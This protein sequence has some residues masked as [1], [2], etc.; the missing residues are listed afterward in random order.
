MLSALSTL[1]VGAFSC[2]AALAQDLHRGAVDAPAPLF[3]LAA[4]VACGARLSVTRVVVKAPAIHALGL[5]LLVAMAVFVSAVPLSRA[6]PV[7]AAAFA[8]LPAFVAGAAYPFV[9]R[10]LGRSSLRARGS[11]RLFGALLAGGAVG[12][13]A[14]EW[15]LV[16][17]L[18]PMRTALAA[19]VLP[20]LVGVLA[21]ALGGRRETNAPLSTPRLRQGAP[22]WGVAL[23]Y[24]LAVGVAL[25]LVCRL[26]AGATASTFGV[27][28]AALLGGFAWG[29]ERG[30]HLHHQ[31]RDGALSR[32]LAATALTWAIGSPAAPRLGRFVST[33]DSFLP[34]APE[35]ALVRGLAAAAIILLPTVWLGAGYTPMIR[36]FVREPEAEAVAFATLLSCAGGALGAALCATLLVPRFGVT[37]T[38]VAL[39]VSLSALALAFAPEPQRRPIAL[40]GAVSSVVALLFR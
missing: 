13:L 39:V 3:A 4:G 20:G 12:V 11:G 32:A 33:C 24:G 27:S 6:L 17:T 28:A 30:K 26:S 37:G 31:Y 25:A 15:T 10:G 16:S 34:T 21:L 29:T 14:G 36:R 22:R 35:R 19:A 8:L 38:V 2:E 40:T 7:G 1:G 9:A 5:A 23:G 18:G